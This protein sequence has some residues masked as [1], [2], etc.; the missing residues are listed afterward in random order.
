MPKP[1]PSLAA[2]I[3]SLMIS[4]GAMPQSCAPIEQHFAPAEDL[5][6]IDVAEIAAAM[7]AQ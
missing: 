3:S 5:E 7:Q 6:R 4:G 1:I 2:L